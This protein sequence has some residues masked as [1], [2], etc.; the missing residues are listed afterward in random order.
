MIRKQEKM[1]HKSSVDSMHSGGFSN[2]S[3]S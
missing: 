3:S 2:N 1:S